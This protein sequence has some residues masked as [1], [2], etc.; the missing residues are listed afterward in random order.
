M[1]KRSIGSGLHAISHMYHHQRQQHQGVYNIHPG[2][3]HRA[4][5]LSL[6][7]PFTYTHPVPDTQPISGRH[8]LMFGTPISSSGQVVLQQIITHMENFVSYEGIFRKSGS[9]NRVDQ[10]VHD[11]GEKDFQQIL[12]SEMYKPHDYATMLKQYFSD[13]PEPLLL[14]RHLNA[15]IQTA[16][17]T[18]P[19]LSNIQC[20]YMTCTVTVCQVF[21]QQL[22]PQRACSC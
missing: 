8:Q 14:K 22:Q 21:T 6:S 15:Y 20:M 7:H 3:S 1:M 12:L 11:L 9:K 19:C 10:L 17:D 4:F 18:A 5:S 13:L 16:G 2:T